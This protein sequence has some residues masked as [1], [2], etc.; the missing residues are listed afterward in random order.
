MVSRI[1]IVLLLFCTLAYAAEPE[2]V[3]AC[4][5]PKTNWLTK[6]ERQEIASC[7]HWTSANAGFCMGHYGLMPYSGQTDLALMQISADEVSF[8]SNQ[9]SKLHGKIEVAYED[10]ILNAETA[11]VDRDP[12]THKIR[13]IIFFDQVRYVSAIGEMRANRGTFYPEDKTTEII[14]VLYRLDNKGRGASISAWGRASQVNRVK[15]GQIWMKNATFTH[16][17]PLDNAW[18][19]KAKSLMLDKKNNNGV[20]KGARLEVLDWPVLYTPYLNFPITKE[21]KS[22]FLMPIVGSTSTLGFDLATPYYLNLAPN[23]DATFVP[24]FY[25]K[26]GVMVGGEFRYLTHSSSGLFHGDYLSHDRKYAQFLSTNSVNYPSLANQPNDRW[27]VQWVDATTLFIPNLLLAV[28]VSQYSDDYYLQDFS[29]N[30]ARV[31]TRQVLRQGTLDYSSDHWLV[32]G[33]LLSYQTFNPINETPINGIYDRLPQLTA[34]GQYDNLPLDSRLQLIGTFDS[35]LWSNNLYPEPN[36]RRFHANP[37][38]SIDKRASWG[39]IMPSVQ[40]VGNTYDLTFPSNFPNPP[41]VEQSNISVPRLVVDGGLF[42]EKGIRYFNKSYLQTLEPRL[43]YLYVPYQNQTQIPVFDANYMIFTAQDVFR[44]N[45]FSGY[46]RIGDA[47]Q[48]GYGLTS[49]WIDAESG[50]ERAAILLAQLAYFAKRQVNLCYAPY[51]T[52]QDNPDTIGYISPTAEF[53]PA[54]AHGVYRFNR[55]WSFIGNYVWD[56]A[57]R[58]TNNGFAGFQYLAEFN[59]IVN[60]GYSYLVN[61]DKTQAGTSQVQDNALNQISA[62]YAWPYNDHWSSFG[63]YSYNI[64]K[65]FQMM[66]LLGLQYDSCCWGARVIGGRTFQSLPTLT[67]PTYVNSIFFQ[68]FLKGL[69]SVGTADPTSVLRT[70]L[71]G[72]VD[73]FRY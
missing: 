6:E 63:A 69:G 58:A 15:N 32:H 8:Y 17:S 71:P 56:P 1:R 55:L 46:D 64:A 67:T 48:L 13:Q 38:F 40:W 11:Y 2:V 50:N 5:I 19:L 65:E 28:D 3:K 34:N 37:I 27:T 61:A 57:T 68:V 42:F 33:A 70:Y 43:Y 53:S 66:G 9:R 23:Y 18:N 62:S 29:T 54:A 31:T 30:Y 25:G 10:Q 4:L 73:T 20:A 14:D 49:R 7:L 44:D 45:R 72:Y 39:Y 51:G 60:V 26:R 36:A 24:H 35:F 59:R 12:K 47:N 22:G 41:L 52:C 16:C 21:R